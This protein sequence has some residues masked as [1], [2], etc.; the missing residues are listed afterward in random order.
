[1]KTIA[2]YIVL[3][4]SVQQASLELL[5]SLEHRAIREAAD[6]L[7]EVRAY[8]E[9]MHMYSKLNNAGNLSVALSLRMAS[10]YHRFI[11]YDERDSI[12][13][14]TVTLSPCY[15]SVW[16]KRIQ[17]SLHEVNED[18]LEAILE[19]LLVV[20]KSCDSSPLFVVEGSSIRIGH[21]TPQ[22]ATRND[23]APAMQAG[24]SFRVGTRD[25]RVQFIE[26]QR[27]LGVFDES[28]SELVATNVYRWLSQRIR[29]GKDENH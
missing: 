10:L 13:L 7:Y 4:C 17:Y 23:I 26:A 8:E 20:Q 3:C 2:L 18:R 29:V 14:R 22:K 24:V 25:F 1:M 11:R 6:S 21:V 15:W 27:S 16:A 12:L 19:Q 28:G 5:P 9:A